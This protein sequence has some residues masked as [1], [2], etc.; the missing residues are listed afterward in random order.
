MCRTPGFNTWQTGK[1]FACCGDA[2][3]FIE[4]AGAADIKS[5]YLRVEGELMTHIVHDLGISGGAAVKALQSLRRDEGPTAYIFQC[6]K[7]QS[8][9]AFMD[10]VYGIG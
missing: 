1:W 2:M 3:T 4:P 6:R 9:R 5:K 7:C 8:Q 10:G